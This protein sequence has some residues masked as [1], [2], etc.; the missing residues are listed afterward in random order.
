M[1]ESLWVLVVLAAVV[2]SVVVFITENPFDP[3][4]FLSTEEKELVAW[5]R[6]RMQLNPG[7]THHLE[8]FKEMQKNSE[9]L[10]NVHSRILIGA[11]PGERRLLTIG[12]SAVPPPQGSSLVDTLQSLFSA[13]SSSERRHFTVLLHVAGPDPR[14][15]AQ[16][17]R[18]LSAVFKPHIRARD[19]VV[20]ASPPASLLPLKDLKEAARDPPAHVAFRSLQSV[21]HAFLMNF[22]AQHSPYFLMVEEGVKCAPGFVTQIATTLSAWEH[23][24]WV[25][26][27]FSRRG[28]AGKLFH[29][30][31]LPRIARFLLLFHQD[32][33]FDG[34]LSHFQDLVQP[35]PIRFLPALF[36]RVGG[37]RSSQEEEAGSP[38]NP[39][40]SLHTSLEG[41]NGSVPSSAYSLDESFFYAKLAEA[42]SHL[43]VV[44]D[45]P[46][47]VSRVRVQTGSDL[48]DENQLKEGQVELG[49]DAT[50]LVSDCD[51]YVLLGLLVDGSLD[52]QVLS[53]ESGRKVKCV[54]LLVTAR[55][56][57]GVVL[58]HIGLWTK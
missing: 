53:H 4:S 9:P 36:Q 50:N 24:P 32:V 19:L 42:G 48:G 40:A 56:P 28:L 47:Q 26:L 49:Y 33:P 35:R 12:I 55:A 44:L 46:A 37:P 38:S 30:G 51:D 17:T 18:K 5:Q 6:A 58:R 41:A 43:T 11:P 1:R 3:S 15:L 57:S 54:R 13:A 20:I 22:A 25:T 10:K 16:V 21:G 2:L 34:L 52:R 7:R 45:T 8:T 23:R 27:E 31:D 29:A 14:W 39:A